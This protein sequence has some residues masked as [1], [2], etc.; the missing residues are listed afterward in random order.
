MSKIEYVNKI[1][2]FGQNLKEKY[3]EKQKT[4]NK[5]KRNKVFEKKWVFSDVSFAEFCKWK[6]F[7]P[8][9]LLLNT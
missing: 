4:K 6:L 9:I 5:K 1:Q 8:E 2:K 7:I 3:K